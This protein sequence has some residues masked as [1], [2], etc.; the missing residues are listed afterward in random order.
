MR[1][2]NFSLHPLAPSSISAH[3]Y[4]PQMSVGLS[5]APTNTSIHHPNAPQPTTGL[6]FV[7]T[8]NSIHQMMGHHLSPPQGGAG[9]HLTCPNTSFT[10]LPLPYHNAEHGIR[11]ITLALRVL[12]VSIVCQSVSECLRVN[13][14]VTKTITLFEINKRP[15]GKT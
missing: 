11:K 14:S 5:F 7:P 13:W 2:R 1:V 9:L 12:R 10:P 8:D 3:P 15:I 6:S 4:T